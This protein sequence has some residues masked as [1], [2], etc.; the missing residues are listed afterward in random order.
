MKRVILC[1]L[2]I[3][4]FSACAEETSYDGKWWNSVSKDQRTEFIAG[5]IDC[6]S[7]DAGQLNLANASWNL[8]EPKITKFYRENA[9]NLMK[10]VITVLLQITLQERPQKRKDGEVFSEKHGIFDGEYWR[11]IMDE[12]RLGFIEGYLAC[13]KQYNKPAASFSREAQWYVT[14]ISN[15]YGIR[16]DNPSEINEKR[17]SKKIADVL[18][19]FK[20]KVNTKR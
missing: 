9:S 7:D 5:Y 6:A 8:L 14:Q 15:W 2:F 16:A 3:S 17:S 20:D 19:L 12:E 11:Q 10:P 18:F 13:Q 4:S 1:I